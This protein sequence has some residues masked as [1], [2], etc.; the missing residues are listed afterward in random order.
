MNHE[1]DQEIDDGR[2]FGGLTYEDFVKEC[3]EM[4]PGSTG[5]T[6]DFD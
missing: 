1:M 2:D 4:N 3:E 5:Y 6:S